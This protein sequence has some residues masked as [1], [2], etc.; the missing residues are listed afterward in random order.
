M[1]FLY[2]D[3]FDSTFPSLSEDGSAGVL[4]ENALWLLEQRYFARRFDPSSGTVRKESSFCEF[5]RRVSRIVAAA[6]TCYLDGSEADLE[7]LRRLEANIFS[8]IINRRFLFNSPCLF[9]AGAGMTVDPALGP[10][11]YCPPEEMT[12][13]DYDLLHRSKTKSQ[14]LFACFVIDVPDSIDGIFDGVKDAA[15][16][17][18]YGGG[19]GGNFGWLR[20]RGSPISGGIG[21]QA[22]GPV[23]FMETWNTMGA[24]VVQGGRR[25]AA[26]MGMLF[27]DHPDIFDFIDAKVEEGRLP[28]FNISVCVSDRLME[29]SEGGEFGLISRSDG[30]VIRTVNGADLWNKLCESAWRRGDPGIFFIDRANDDNLLKLDDTWKIESTNPC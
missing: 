22:S 21:G 18:K 30:K 16:I 15:V 12:F 13:D 11:I 4:S 23:S 10:K 2:K 24:V 29:V 17:S 28:Y 9:A 5:A 7:W 19:V 25:R 3:R 1:A 27:D 6:E 14:Q 8:D 26:L 20:E